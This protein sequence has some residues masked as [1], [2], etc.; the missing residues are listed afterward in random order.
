[1]KILRAILLVSAIAAIGAG[2]SKPT[3]RVSETGE[4][5]QTPKTQANTQQSATIT[6]P[7]GMPSYTLEEVG[8]HATST[9]CWMVIRDKVY[10]VT[11]F[12][13]KHPGGNVIL[14]GCGKEA[15]AL[16]DNVTKHQGREAQTLLIRLEIGSLAK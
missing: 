2:C 8:S 4:S 3:T 7:Q 10:D 16:F 13:N 11:S 9:D 14:D 15:T 6:T 1:M 5:P 12:V